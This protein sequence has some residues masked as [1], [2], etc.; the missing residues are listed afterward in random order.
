MIVFKEDDIKET[1]TYSVQCQMCHVRLGHD[2][3]PKTDEDKRHRPDLSDGWG[4]DMYWGAP[5]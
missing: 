3:Y 4:P 2:L 5:K 1:T